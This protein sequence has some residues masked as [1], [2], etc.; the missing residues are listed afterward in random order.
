MKKMKL[1]SMAGLCF[2]SL[3]TSCDK[4]DD[5]VGGGAQDKERKEPLVIAHRGAQSIYPE[6]TLKA[7]AKAIEMGADYIEPDLVMTKDSVL[8]ARHEPFISGTTNVADLPEFADLK[9]TKNLDGKRITDWFVSDFTLEQIKKLKAKQAR[10]D[11]SNSFD[12]MFQIPTLDE[13]IALAKSRKTTKGEKVGIYPE[14]K[15]PYFHNQLGLAIEDALLEKLSEA[16]LN[17]YHSPVFVQ[18]FE[19]APLQY[20]NSKSDVK[21]V[22]LISTYNVNADGTLDFNV[23]EGDFISYAAPFDFYANGDARTYEYFSTEEGMRFASEYAD[24]IGPWKPFVISF[25]R[26]ESGA[27]TVLPKTDFID[28]AHKY[29]LDVHPYTFRNEDEKWSN[30]NAQAEYHL[31]F[32]AG[33]DGV[34]TDYTDEAVNAVR[35]WEGLKED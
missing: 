14:M 34:F 4:L 2:L 16:K 20:I 9:T 24:G 3:F 5:F 12:G 25:S 13:I 32:D 31:F 26:D 30:G 21:L 6:H 11:R 23:P 27:I 1:L 35:T 18:C 29:D 7:Y 33:V 8:I 22:Q 15:H 10:S 28:L 19:V 17:S